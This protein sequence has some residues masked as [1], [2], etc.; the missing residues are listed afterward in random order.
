MTGG[1]EHGKTYTVFSYFYPDTRPIAQAPAWVEEF[2][3]ERGKG[4]LLVGSSATAED[5]IHDGLKKITVPR[6]WIWREVREGQYDTSG[7]KPTWKT[8]S[9]GA[10][11]AAAP[12]PTTTP[13]T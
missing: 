7:V 2:S 11:P 4:E 1:F 10:G 8:P 12:P 9:T 5:T 6:G 13:T 3:F